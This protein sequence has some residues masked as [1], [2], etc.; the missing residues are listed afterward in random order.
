MRHA[1]RGLATVLRRSP[2]WRRSTGGPPAS[3]ISTRS[4]TARS[5]PSSAAGTSVTTRN[6]RSRARPIPSS[7]RPGTGS[8][9]TGPKT[10]SSSSCAGAMPDPA[11]RCMEARTSARSSACSTGRWSHSATPRVIWGGGCSCSA[12]VSRPVAPSCSRACSTVRPPSPCG[13]NSWAARPRT[14][15]STSCS[16][17]S[18][19]V[20]SW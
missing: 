19:S 20:W 6:G 4:I 12:S 7:T 14:W 8:S 16:P 11:T 10:A 5:V 3:T 13:K 2:G 9:P 15:R 18:S 17:V 1:Q